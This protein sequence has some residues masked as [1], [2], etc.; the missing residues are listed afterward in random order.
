MLR[1]AKKYFKTLIS[2]IISK[3]F[4]H[5]FAASLLNKIMVFAGS[6]LLVRI[7]SKEDYGV[8]AYA[9][10]IYGFVA[11]FTGFGATSGM[12][13]LGSE[14]SEINKRNDIYNFGCRVGIL[15]NIFLSIIIIGIA[16]FIHLPIAGANY[17]L[18]LLSLLP[19][20]EVISSMQLI[21]LRTDLRNKEYSAANMISTILVFITSVA[22]SILFQAKGLI[23]SYYISYIV[24]ILTVSKLFKLPFSIKHGNLS[25]LDKKVFLSISGISMLNNGVSQLMYLLDVFILGIVTADGNTIAAYKVATKIPTALSFIPSVII[26]FVYPYFARNKDNK[27]WC[28]RYTIIIMSLVGIFNLIISTILFMM[29][30]QIINSIFGNQYLDSV[31]PFRILCISYIFSGSVRIFAGNFLV[32][33]RK[34]KFNL[35]DA[36]FSGTLN[37]TLNLWLIPR[38]QSCGAA[39]A[40][41]ITTFFSSAISGGYLIYVYNK[42]M[43]DSEVDGEM[44]EHGR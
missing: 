2:K 21:Y 31:R 27:K 38:Y 8:Y 40:T 15:F 13:Q 25:E 35:F 14:T 7:I 36:V 41:L 3:G 44:V 30:P 11:I 37:T 43:H 5:I 29:A 20:A 4:I 39:I 22:M 32:A 17:Y 12:L 16:R 33:Q 9:Y 26:T 42:K 1:E 18:L 10:N 34:L 23:W 28:K 19:I 6:I 24:T